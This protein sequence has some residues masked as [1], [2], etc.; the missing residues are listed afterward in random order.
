MF[1]RIVDRR[2]VMQMKRIRAKDLAHNT[3]IRLL[4]TTII[5]IQKENVIQKS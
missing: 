2:I 5:V 4:L 1:K 3:I